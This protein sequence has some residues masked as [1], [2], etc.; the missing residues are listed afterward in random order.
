VNGGSSFIDGYLHV[1]LQAAFA[2]TTNREYV[3][4]KS[5]AVLFSFPVSVHDI[6]VPIMIDTKV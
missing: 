5:V 6:T 2:P 4:K 1:L 3:S